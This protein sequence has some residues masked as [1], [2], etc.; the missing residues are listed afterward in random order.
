MRK[1]S[2]SPMLTLAD[3][4]PGVF[5]VVGGTRENGHNL[6]ATSVAS[7][8]KTTQHKPSHGETLY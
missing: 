1:V 8:L 3:N 5:K 2:L 4:Q 6:L 7:L